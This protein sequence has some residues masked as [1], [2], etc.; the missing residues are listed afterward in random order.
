MKNWVFGSIPV[1]QF[2]KAQFYNSIC[3]NDWCK[4]IRLATT[5]SERHFS[6]SIHIKEALELV[7]I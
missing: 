3:T 7:M 5:R 2:D 6:N 4:G 1:F